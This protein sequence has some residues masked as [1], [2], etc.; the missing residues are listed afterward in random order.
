[1]TANLYLLALLSCA[2]ERCPE[3][4]VLLQG[5]KF[6]LGE[7]PPQFQWQLM[8][9]P[10]EVSSF[11]MDRFEFPNRQGEYPKSGVTFNEAKDQCEQLGK[12][13]CSE[14]EWE[15][16]CQGPKGRLY[17]YGDDRVEGIC[18]TQSTTGEQPFA[19]S[20]EYPKCHSPE[21]V[22]DLNGN[23][24]E[25][26]D[27]TWSQTKTSA[28]GWKTLRGGTIEEKTHYG[29]DCTSRHGHDANNWRN[30]DDGFRCCAEPRL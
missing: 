5:G 4:M 15:Y 30:S 26:V 11:C 10:F 29:Q 17:S 14:P 9:R 16:A 25:W 8:G 13:L 24:S 21:G 18:H 22:F 1:M 12:R 27:A 28:G 23:L 19:K 7:E 20:G 2:K 6:T 3:G